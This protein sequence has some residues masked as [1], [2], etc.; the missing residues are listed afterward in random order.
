[1]SGTFNFDSQAQRLICLVRDCVLCYLEYEQPAMRRVRADIFRVL[2]VRALQEAAVTCT[3]LIPKLA[4][5]VRYGRG[6][7]M[8][9]E[10]L[11]RLVVVGVADPVRCSLV[12]VCCSFV[13]RKQMPSIRLAV[14]SSLDQRLDKYLAQSE[15]LGTLFVALNDEVFAIREV[16]CRT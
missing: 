1:M 10:V 3:R 15:I 13:P 2:T 14:L 6:T 9:F 8:I 12:P 7:Q 16:G 5:S 4:E 11:K